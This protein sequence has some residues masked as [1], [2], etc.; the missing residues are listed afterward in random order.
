[1]RRPAALR[2]S[3]FVWTNNDHFRFLFLF[4]MCVFFFCVCAGVLLPIESVRNGVYSSTSFR[5]CFFFL[6]V[7]AY[8][9]SA[10][11]SV[12]HGVSVCFGLRFHYLERT[13]VFIFIFYFVL[14]AMTSLFFAC[15]C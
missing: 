3:F 6:C 14:V 11:E 7:C 12:R 9:C 13:H 2:S 4:F 1:M 15:F 5:S 10:V 8:Q